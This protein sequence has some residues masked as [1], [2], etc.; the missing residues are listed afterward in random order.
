[1]KT[2]PAVRTSWTDAL[3]TDDM[4]CPNALREHLQE[5]HRRH[6]GFTERCAS[7]CVDDNG[8]TSYEWL[9]EAID[10]ERHNA[11]LDLACGSGFFLNL[12]ADRFPN[13]Q[14]LCG[15]DMSGA[16]LALA[17]KRLAG[18]GVVLYEGLAQDLSFS[19]D[20]AFNAA[21]CHWALTL[22]DPV[23]PVLR[24][25]RRVVAPGG[26]F[27]A[28]VDGDPAA[29]E[30]YTE[31]NEIVFEH[32]RSELPAYVGKDL[33]DPRTRQPERLKMLACDAFETTSVSVQSA[34]FMLRGAPARLAEEVVGFFYAAYVLSEPA[35]ERL[36]DELTRLF[37]KEAKGGIATFSMP[38]CRLVA[39]L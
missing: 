39:S 1:M 24:E 27:S 26:V 29:A 25:I 37:D 38:V 17:E 23:E 22:M 13:T 20:G 21:L 10:P 12:C 7:K 2:P 5:V 14:T 11:I 3:S 34:P 35:R 36:I 9:S 28:I 15:V 6:P 16:E 32:V 30:G 8:R 4:P 33:G 19:D 31:I 18:K